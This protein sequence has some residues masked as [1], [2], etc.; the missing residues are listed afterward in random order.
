MSL[1]QHHLRNWDLEVAEVVSRSPGARGAELTRLRDSDGREFL[2]KTI[3]L[4]DPLNSPARLAL[5]HRVI[6][7]LVSRRVRVLRPIENREGRTW[8]VLGDR[9]V[10]L[11]PWLD[12]DFIGPSALA[13]PWGESVGSLH[14]GLGGIA[15]DEVERICGCFDIVEVFSEKDWAHAKRSLDG[16][17]LGRLLRTVEA[18]GADL[19]RK[20]AELTPKV[21]HRDCHPLNV[22]S[23]GSQVLAWIDFDCLCVGLPMFDV[24]NFLGRVLAWRDG[25]FDEWAESAQNFIRGYGTT[26]RLS[27]LERSALPIMIVANMA[28]TADFLC[29]SGN[30]KGARNEAEG[31]VLL[32]ERLEAV[33]AL[34]LG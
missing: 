4:N 21:I 28:G 19:A 34:C 12:T 8:L 24:S 13:L 32:H 17:L 14:E 26:R 3:P 33:K 30:P 15:T 22:L 16:D 11:W 1:L 29:W 7:E 27:D 2:L 9:I 25:S 31:A 23:R 6:S 10:M 20:T 5:Q 18:I